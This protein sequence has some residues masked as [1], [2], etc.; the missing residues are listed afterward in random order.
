MKIQHILIT[1]V[2]VET[3]TENNKHENLCLVGFVS[4]LLTKMNILNSSL[5]IYNLQ[6]VSKLN[7]GLSSIL[8]VLFH[9]KTAAAA[10]AI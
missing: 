1:H 8:I 5:M 3:Q 2:F 7:L 6:F 9:L 10:V 4:L